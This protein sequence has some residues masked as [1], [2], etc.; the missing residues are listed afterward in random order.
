MAQGSDESSE[1]KTEQA[2]QQRREDF[3]KS[4]QVAQSREITSI[5]VLMGVGLLFYFLSREFLQ[6]LG[7]LFTTSFTEY[8]LAAAR[9]GDLMPGIKFAL[10]K[11]FMVIAPVMGIAVLTGI[12][13]TVMQI[14]FLTSWEQVSPDLNR[15]N[16]INGFAKIFNLRNL[17]EGTKSVFKIIIVS[18][19][20]YLVLKK[21]LEFTPQLVQ[22]SV[23][24]IFI[25]IGMV[26]F[27]LLGSICA[28]LVMLAIIDY[29]F[30]RWDLEK[31]MR[32]TKQEVKEEFKQ[33]EG[34]P[35][36]KSRIK[37]IQRE[38]A[39]KRMMDAI[40]KA[41]VVITNP[42]H[43]A[44]VLKYDRENMAAPTLVAKG[45]DLIAEKIKSIARQHN[46]PVVENKPLARTIFKTLKI[47]QAIPKS[48]YNAVAEVLAYVYKIKGKIKQVSEEIA[49]EASV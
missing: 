33:R 39:Q 14:G 41:D 26:I 49:Q 47:G 15:I 2:T 44:V 28:L 13:S 4:G 34:D 20:A 42:T 45:A 22:L 23:A 30:Q 40:P 25:Y 12:L 1:E 31:R 5:L 10:S 18:A 32:M 7:V 11:A 37:R 19:V 21:E 38:L 46:V 29:A 8:F 3:R 43:I 48:L 35:L 27:K 9:H 16:P 24:Q 17:F 6:N 36:I